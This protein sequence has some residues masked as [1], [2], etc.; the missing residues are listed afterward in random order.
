MYATHANWMLAFN[1][2]LGKQ[3]ISGTWCLPNVATKQ[4]SVRQDA[5]GHPW[6]PQKFMKF[7]I[8]ITHHLSTLPKMSGLKLCRCQ[9]CIAAS[10]GMKQLGN[11]PLWWRRIATMKCLLLRDPI[12]CCCPWTPRNSSILKG[13]SHIPSRKVIVVCFKSWHAPSTQNLAIQQPRN[14]L[15]LLW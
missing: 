12:F 11:L 7:Q 4:M 9:I 13:I 1:Q 2:T 14:A 10:S 8:P 3:R 15:N 6:I 5:L